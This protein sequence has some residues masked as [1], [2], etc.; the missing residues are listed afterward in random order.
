ML[1]SGRHG[2]HHLL[3]DINSFDMNIGVGAVS[4]DERTLCNV[5]IDERLNIVGGF[6]RDLYPDRA[7]V[8]FFLDVLFALTHGFQQP[9]IL[10][11]A[12]AHRA[13]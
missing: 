8:G 4:I 2:L 6:T 11:Q 13:S 3:F 5:P 1:E 9:P 10:Q 7:C 12:F